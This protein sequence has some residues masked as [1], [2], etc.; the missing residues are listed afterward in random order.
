MS[1]W[2]PER[3]LRQA[4]LIHKWRPWEKSTGPRTPEGKLR[5]GQNAYKNET[6]KLLRKVARQLNENHQTL[7]RL[8]EVGLSHSRK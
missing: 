7:I 4:A 5:V 3:R 1:N 2:T 6:R 8:G